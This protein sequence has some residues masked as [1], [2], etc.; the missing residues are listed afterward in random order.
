AVLAYACPPRHPKV[1]PTGE[2]ISLEFAD[3]PDTPPSVA[4]GRVDHGRAMTHDQRVKAVADL[5]AQPLGVRRIFGRSTPHV[6]P[7]R[8]PLGRQPF[9]I[10]EPLQ[11][12][13]P[14]ADDVVLANVRV[15]AHEHAR[16]RAHTTA[17]RAGLTWLANRERP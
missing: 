9:P 3:Q 16:P 8:L 1:A 12:L 5:A 4:H 11:A 10:G 14:F 2:S 17:R 13:Q 15:A 6:T 7:T